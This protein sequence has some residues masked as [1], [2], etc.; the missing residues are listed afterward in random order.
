L[1]TIP[2]YPVYPFGGIIRENSLGFSYNAPGVETQIRNSISDFKE[3]NGIAAVQ[4]DVVAHSMGGD[5]MRH[6]A[7]SDQFLSNDTYGSGPVHKLIT[8]GTPDLGSPLATMLLQPQNTCSRNVLALAGNIAFDRV[9]IRGAD[10]YGGDLWLWPSGATAD[11]SVGSD[12][13]NFLQSKPLPFPYAMI[14][15]RVTYDNLKGLD[16]WVFAGTLRLCAIFHGDPLAGALTASGWPAIFNYAA[17]DGVVPVM[18]QVYGNWGTVFD[19]I[20]HSSGVKIL[21]FNGPTELDFPPV[22]DKVREL[23]DKA[24]DDHDFIHEY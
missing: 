8:I 3:K 14:A 11:L 16:F 5:V 21:G 6:M 12:A 24:V 22:V 13:L 17:S 9:L 1:D 2:K 18:S 19:G 15:G 4:A 23:L 10:M 20:V 7:V